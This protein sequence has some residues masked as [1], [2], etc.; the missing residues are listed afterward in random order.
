MGPVAVIDDIRL[1][2]SAPLQDQL[3]R[4]LSRRIVDQRFRPGTTLPSSRQL[5]RD[6]GVSRN[7]VNAVYDQLKAEG[8]LKTRPGK[9]VFVSEDIEAALNQ[10]QALT[11]EPARSTLPL[12]PVPDI[13]PHSLR[14]AQDANLPFQPG[15]PDLD[16]FPIR[17]WN[18]IL[19]H[20]ESRKVLRGY[21][22]IQG[23]RPLREAVAE[24]VRTA[25]GVRCEAHQV[26]ITNGA[27]QALSLIAAVLLQPGDPVLCENPGYRGSRYALGQHGNPLVPVPLK[28]QVLDVDALEHLGPARLLFCTPTHQYPM[29]GILDIAQRMALLRWA[30]RNQTWIIED[31]YDSEFH[32]YNKPFAAI[33]GLFDSAPVLYVGSFSKTL[34]PGLR[35]GYLVVPEA[36]IDHFLW[37]KRVNGGETPLL[38]QATIAEFIRSGQFTSH[39]RRMR[40]LYRDKWRHFQALVQERLQGRVTPVAE[41]AG[42]HLV[43]EG[44]FDDVALSQA[45]RERGFGST[46]LS[47][48]YLGDACQTG[49]V[50]GFASASERQMADCVDALHSL[51]PGAPRS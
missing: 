20:Q 13:P 32:F 31:D 28:N 39:L 19:H 26:M 47:V 16:A 24:Y 43:L 40:Q 12:P 17:S 44:D 6:L 9:G 5:A 35:V 48:H 51:L 22:E 3:Y 36:L 38:T 46:P 21:N 2:A 14:I 4:Q 41:S 27:Q 33:Q 15:L 7:T 42:M 11:G 37:A 45:L 29:G 23:Y 25:R 49:L 10:P 34:M 30:Q 8:F 50:M 1:D 18:R